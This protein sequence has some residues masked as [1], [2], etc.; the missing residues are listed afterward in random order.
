[1][2]LENIVARALAQ[3][4]ICDGLKCQSIDMRWVKDGKV[5]MEFRGYPYVGYCAEPDGPMIIIRADALEHLLAIVWKAKTPSQKYLKE[6]FI[7]KNDFKAWLEKTEQP[8]PTF[9]FSE[10]KKAVKV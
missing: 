1:M 3:G 4:I 2:N 7:F 10:S 6:E 8:L 9:W 5:Q